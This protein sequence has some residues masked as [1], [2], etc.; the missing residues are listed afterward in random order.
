MPCVERTRS[1]VAGF[2]STGK[3]CASLQLRT[4]HGDM[5]TWQML[6]LKK[7]RSHVL[8]ECKSDFLFHLAVF[9]EENGTKQ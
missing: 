2:L 7:M 1:T 4:G 8:D 3:L 5:I 6:N 9:K